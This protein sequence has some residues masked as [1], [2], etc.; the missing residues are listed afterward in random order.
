[1]A[2]G[3]LSAVL[4]GEA[5]W[6]LHHGDCLEMLRMLPDNSVDLGLTDPPY[7]LSEHPV[8]SI[9]KALTCWLAGEPYVHKKKGFLSS[10]WDSFVPGPEVWRE[11]YRVLRPGAHLIVF[12]GTRTIDLMGIA[13]RLA[14]FEVRDTPFTAMGAGLLGA[15]V[16]GQGMAKSKKA[17]RA[18]AMELCE[19]DGDHYEATLPKPKDRK[20][21]DHLCPD[22]PEGEPYEGY[23]TALAPK[24]EP[25]LIVRKPLDGT[26]GANIV[27]HGTGTLHIDACR[28]AHASP[29]DLADHQAT[30]AAIKERGGVM[31]NSWKNDSDLSGASDVNLDGR[32]APNFL[33][34]HDARCRKVGTSAV[35]A[36]P[37][38]NTPNRDTAPSA[39]TG[40][41]VSTVR[42]VSRAGEAS[43][44]RR[45]DD[46]GA[47]TF[48]ATPGPRR[49]DEEA[50]EV[51]ECHQDCPCLALD[52]QS[53]S[54]RQNGS[55]SGASAVGSRENGCYGDSSA[56]RGEF[57]GYGDTG[58]ASRYFPQF[59]WDPE[60]D[61][62][63]PFQ[64]V[65]KARQPERDRGLDHFRHR[66]AAEVTGSQDGQERLKNARTGAGRTK[67]AKNPH[68]TVKPIELI[69]WLA[70]LGRPAQRGPH[71]PVVVIPF[72][73]AGSEMIAC[74]LE[75]MRV[76][77]SELNDTD[78]LP[79]CTVARARINH[80]EG[81]TLIPR[82][83]L[84]AAEPPRQTSL[85][86]VTK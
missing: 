13:L 31:G 14:G 64:Y 21:G 15:W 38:W 53:G 28:V 75:N 47:T 1:L 22:V 84:R 70:R 5:Q 68:G 55:I 69:R 16:Q 76:I 10:T 57:A 46:R 39:F 52:R 41:E 50:I 23:G 26:I 54:G 25:I 37:T 51:Y 6:S 2:E 83:S 72:G 85:F 36:N 29:E 30:V 60:I 86:T 20:E 82:E 17:H 63:S 40:D 81:R 79:F 77:A 19:L 8:K 27:K 71:A 78:E 35:K 58:G 49:D 67:G 24:Y 32:W 56:P 66:S 33:L 45:Y 44:E 34:V 18:V 80:I 65:A 73:G 43:A 61:D 59:Q 42:H 12:A 74:L 62:L 3:S 48:A 11:V 4:T 7:G 9:V